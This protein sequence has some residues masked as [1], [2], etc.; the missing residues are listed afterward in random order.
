V[1]S[2]SE[3]QLVTMYCR[4]E[5][6]VRRM[7]RDIAAWHEWEPE[8]EGDENP[9]PEPKPIAPGLYSRMESML[10]KMGMSPADRAR[11]GVAPPQ[12]ASDFDDI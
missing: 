1:L 4:V 3:R 5:A 2:Q 7:G 9:K 10:G 6:D 12:D 8:F 11:V